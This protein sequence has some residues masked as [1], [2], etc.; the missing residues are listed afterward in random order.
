MDIH[1]GRGNAL[2][3]L[4]G[5]LQRRSRALPVEIADLKGGSAQNAIPR[6]A[7]AIVVLDA[8]REKELKSLVATA[9]AEYKADLG[10]FDP[11]LQ[12]TVEKAER[13]EKVF[14]AG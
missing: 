11:D 12:I 5:V 10:G 2:R 9:E 6:E 1:Q 3:I 4:G 7:S 8:S 13:P 14:D